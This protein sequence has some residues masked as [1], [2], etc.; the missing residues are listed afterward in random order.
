[1]SR[2][3]LTFWGLTE[4]HFTK[5]DDWYN[6]YKKYCMIKKVGILKFKVFN[7]WLKNTK[8]L[9]QIKLFKYFRLWKGFKVWHKTIKW[10]KI[11]NAKKFLERNLFKAD[12]C[13]ARA[14]L[15][16][17]AECC[18]LEE[19]KFCIFPKLENWHVFY[20]YEAQMAELECTKSLLIDFRNR[21]RDILCN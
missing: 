13:L 1:M 2:E 7:Y 21:M 19:L 4:N 3:G 11:E 5:L 16:L 12:P 17:Q 9:F 6:E 18:V 10:K 20:F 14:L 8:K 15:K